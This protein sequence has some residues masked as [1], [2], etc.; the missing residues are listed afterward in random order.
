M[1]LKLI[2]AFF[3]VQ[4]GF[5]QQRTCG[6]EQ[7]M[8]RIMANPQ[9]KQQYLETQAKF[10]IELQKLQQS[11]IANKIGATNLNTVATIKI[12]VAIHFPDETTPSACLR[13]LAQNQVNILNADYNAL[14]SDISQWTTASTFFPGVSIGSLNVQFVIAN[15][16]HP[17]GTGLVNGDLAVTFG[18]DFLGGADNDTTWNGYLNLVC[19]DAG[20]GILGYSP[21]GGTPNNGATVVIAYS[22][23]GSGSG[24]SGYVP[25][26][27]YN[28]GRTL[29]HEL[30]HFFNLNHTFAGCTTASNCA[31]SGDKVCDTPASNAAV[32]GC[33]T[34][35]ATVKCS[36]KTL[37]MNY[38]DYT[39]DACMYM[40]TAGQA[41]RMLAYYN[42][43]SNQLTT[44]ALKNDDFLETNF[45]IFPNPNKGE[46][47][48]KLK[49]AMDDYS[50]QIYDITGR[51]IF[52]KDYIQNQNLEQSISINNSLLGIY[53][54]SIKSNGAILTKKII[55][56]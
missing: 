13:T 26:A 1:K 16:N 9:L 24:C 51:V 50:I 3:I 54:V 25:G 48:I 39:N 46:F 27:P 12:P 31:T 41:T 7:Q 53:F 43:I 10:E 14:N 56:E 8:Q 19:R 42:A 20:S 47:N 34:V 2:L 15:Q 40:F 35:G 30:G 33:P 23:F 22:A 18:T 44:T 49:T 45:S 37:T 55:V 52:E 11:Q 29:T 5:A 38:M 21:L 32:Y 17:S 6:V 28:L 36:V 4:L